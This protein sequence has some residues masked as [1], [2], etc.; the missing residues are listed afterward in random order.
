[1]SGPSLSE[2]DVA[3]AY[4]P[5]PNPGPIPSTGIFDEPTR[6]A[7]INAQWVSHILGVLDRLDQ[8]DAWQGTLDQVDDARNQIR[9]LMVELATECPE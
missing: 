5:R 6:C 8:P 3:G 9:L 7:R 2:E 1:M 4:D